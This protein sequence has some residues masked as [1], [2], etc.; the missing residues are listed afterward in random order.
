MNDRDEGFMALAIKEARRA[1]L[2]GDVPV[3]ALVVREE[4]VISA[5]S[6][7]KERDPTAH[8]EIL[9]I[10][11]AASALETWNLTGCTLYVTAEPC[12]MCAG[13]IVLARVDRLVYGCPD[14]RAGACGTLYDIV[15]DPRLNHRCSVR[16]GVLQGECSRLL[17]DYF[18]DRRKDRSRPR[19]AKG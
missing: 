4:K 19:A 9:A 11:E 7:R 16:K 18:L 13:A 3:G 1:A 12:P 10:R 6:N 17:T 14:P 8:A 2:R 5:A 15:R